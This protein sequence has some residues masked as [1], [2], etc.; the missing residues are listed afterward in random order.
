MLCSVVL[1][2]TLESPLDFKVI[3]PVNPKGN[4]FWIFIARTDA[5]AEAP[6]LRPPDEKSWLIWKDPYAW[7]DWRQKKGMTEDEMFGWHHWL[8]G[9]EFAQT[10]RDSEGQGS[11]AC[12]NSRGHKE[13]DTTKWLRELVMDREARRGAIHGVTKNGTQLSD[14]GSW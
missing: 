10:P 1:E 5:E 2:K 13:L 4:Q 7:K 11:P 9:H 6:I 8:N 14:S 12:C 3:Q